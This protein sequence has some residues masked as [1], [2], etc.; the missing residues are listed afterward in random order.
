MPRAEE[1]SPHRAQVAG[2]HACPEC[3]NGPGKGRQ[4]LSKAEIEGCW[5]AAIVSFASS[6]TAS[7]PRA[8]TQSLMT[9]A[10]R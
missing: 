3:L 10:T 1:H 6:T 7:L 4:Y 5:L 8:K 2:Q 9:F